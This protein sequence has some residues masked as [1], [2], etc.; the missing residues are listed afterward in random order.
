[1]TTAPV[2]SPHT[3]ASRQRIGVA[4]VAAAAVLW[5]LIGLFTL[6]LSDAGY[7]PIDIAWWRALGTAT[8]FWCELVVRRRLPALPRSE[9][10]ALLAFALIGVSLFYLALPAA[11]VAGGITVAY[12]LLYSAPVWVVLGGRLFLGTRVSPRALQVVGLAT[13]GVLLVVASGGGQ[14]TLSRSAVLWGLAAGVSY[15]SYY[16]LGAGL[17]TRVG[18]TDVYALAMLV[19]AVPLGILAGFTVP[20]GT[21]WWLTAGLCALS[22]WLPYVLLGEGLRRLGPVRS[23]VIANLEPVVAALLG[24][25]VAGERLGIVGVCGG[26]LVVTA[27]VLMARGAGGEPVAVSSQP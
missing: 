10:P 5:A 12:V 4:C 14:P 16:L 26:L 19:G 3:P 1:V 17:F 20:S 18:T 23:V 7:R 11:V 15:S 24:V 9:R 2:A 25:V 22:T 13:L 27:S 21:A 6:R 8:L